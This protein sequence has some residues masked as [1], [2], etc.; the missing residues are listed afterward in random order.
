MKPD[1]LRDISTG[2]PD[3]ADDVAGL[4]ISLVL[5]VAVLILAPVLVVVLAVLLFSVELP[6]AIAVGLLIVVARFSGLIPWT[7]LTIDTVTGDGTRVS[8][9]NLFNAIRQVRDTNQ[10]RRVRVRW[11]WV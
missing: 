3:F 1:T 10:D 8:Y 2:F 11:A 5:M 9:R 6:I 4:V 7:V